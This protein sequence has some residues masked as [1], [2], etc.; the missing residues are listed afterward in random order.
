MFDNVTVI[1]KYAFSK[2][3]ELTN[4]NIPRSLRSIEEGLFCQDSKLTKVIIPNG[5]ENIG[6]CAFKECRNLT[7][8]SYKG[9]VYNDDSFLVN[10]LKENNVELRC[11]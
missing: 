3:P 9:I 1:E 2:C 5:I 7:S 11:V 4:I 8:V 10:A 6:M